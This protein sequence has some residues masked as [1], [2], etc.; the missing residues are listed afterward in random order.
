VGV[1]VAYGVCVGSWDRFGQYVAPRA[2]GPITALSRQAS[3]TRAY[4][5]II[6]ANQ[7][8]HALILVHDDLEIIDPEAEAKVLRAFEDSDVVIA[9]VGGGR[10]LRNLA[11][12]AHD[13]IGRQL[14]DSG[15][16]DFGAH[17]GDVDFC[18]GSFLA[19]SP[20]AIRYLR[21]DPWYSFHGYE[22]ICLM[23]RSCHKRVVIIDLDTHHHAS[24]GWRSGQRLAAWQDADVYFRSKW[25]L[26]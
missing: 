8:A 6:D 14:T 11:W 3:I 18:D 5:R 13:P 21:F 19:L 17:E 1:T 23:A 7:D 25:S 16:V 15:I 24:L 26:S 10:N 2:P 9:G 4:N 22:D 12:W 20:W